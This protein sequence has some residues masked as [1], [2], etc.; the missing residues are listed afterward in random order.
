MD[1][2]SLKNH[3]HL[4]GNSSRP[5]LHEAKLRSAIEKEF[6][7]LYVYNALSN[8]VLVEGDLVDA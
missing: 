4:F 5:T 8:Q 6:L 1:H 2:N 3:L 7:A